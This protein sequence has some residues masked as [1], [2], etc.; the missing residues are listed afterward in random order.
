MPVKFSPD[1]F[2]DIA[3]DPSDLPSQISGNNEISGAMKRCTNLQLDRMGIAATRKGSSRVNSASMGASMAPS[4]IMEQTGKR[5]LFSE[6]QIYENEISI[7]DGLAVQPWSAIKYNPFNSI[8]Q[9]I[10]ATNG[11]DR[12]RI[13]NGEVQSWGLEAPLEVPAIAQGHKTGLTGTYNVKYTYARK[14]GSAIVYESNPSDEADSAMV[15]SNESLW[16]MFPMTTDPQI[17]A[18]RVYRTENSGT[19]YLHLKDIEKPPYNDYSY[20]YDW[21]ATDGYISGTGYQI[22]EAVPYTSELQLSNCD[23][24]SDSDGTWSKAVGVNGVLIY[25]QPSW[26][27]EG[28]ASIEM[29]VPG[30]KNGVAMFTKGSGAWD[31]SVYDRLN[32]YLY[33]PDTI[34]DVYLYFGQTDYDEQVT[35]SFTLTAGAG[36]WTQKTWDISGISEADRKA[37]TKIGVRL[38]NKASGARQIY[39]DD[40]YADVTGFSMEGVRKIFSWEPTDTTDEYGGV[41]IQYWEPVTMDDNT[42]DSSLG[43]PVDEDH[44]RPPAG[45]YVFGPSYTGMCFMT[46]ENLLYY[47]REKRPEYWPTDYFLEVSNKDFHLKAGTLHNGQ[48]HVASTV[49]I[50]MIPGTSH[51]TFG[52]PIDMQAITGTQSRNC[53]LSVAGKGIFHLG[54]DGLY[55]YSDSGD[56]NLTNE[57]FKPIHDGETV[58]SIPGLDKTYISN[59]WL[60]AWRNKLYC[61]YPQ[62]GSVYPDQILVTD[63]STGRT[64]H[65][66]YGREFPSV[67][68][69][70]ANDRLL[71]SDTAGYV[72]VIEDPDATDDEGT[73]ISWQIETKN[74]SDQLRKYFPRFARY[75]VLFDNG[76]TGDGYIILDDDIKQTHDL[77]VRN[78]T[79]RLV[80]GCTGNDIAIRMAG[81]GLVQIRAAEVE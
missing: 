79:K 13:E 9:D 14:E 62:I 75:D 64:V 7:K 61:G 52:A 43:V 76:G 58:G 53:F 44:D 10:Y 78:K 66:T 19:D 35:A 55:L 23:S 18:I 49:G 25:L 21:E 77:T 3:T 5:Y 17:S 56:Q 60:I 27:K 4:L 48:I 31:L 63:L 41:S 28:S 81:T 59:C 47:C 22:T 57:K 20:C 36:S 80:T 45:N 54:M 32:F 72:W 65:F 8:N 68:I 16:A 1:G 33:A 40:I 71:A 73:A 50:Y 37:V 51:D 24:M 34:S 74:Y 2:L 69:D 12:I 30:L 70:Y 15:L 38:Q 11:S 42:A 67:G 6:D 29:S 26:K 39:F 46:V